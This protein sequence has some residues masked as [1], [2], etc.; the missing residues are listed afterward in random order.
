[1]VSG[2]AG[3][4]FL[5]KKVYNLVRPGSVTYYITNTISRIDALYFEQGEGGLEGGQVG[6]KVTENPDF[7]HS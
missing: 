3:D 2:H 5:D 6:V 7:T 1:M 4:I